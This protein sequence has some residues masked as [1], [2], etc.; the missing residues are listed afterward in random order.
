MFVLPSSYPELR[1]KHNWSEQD[2]SFPPT[3]TCVCFRWEMKWVFLQF[4]QHSIK[5]EDAKV[6]TNL[7]ENHHFENYF[8]TRFPPFAPPSCS[9]TP[10]KRGQQF[11]GIA[12]NESLR[13]SFCPSVFWPRFCVLANLISFFI[14]SCFCPVVDLFLP[15]FTFVYF[16]LSLST[17]LFKILA[18]RASRLVFFLFL[19]VEIISNFSP[20][21]ANLSNHSRKLLFLFRPLFNRSLLFLETLS[22][23]EIFLQV[24]HSILSSLSSLSFR[25]LW[26]L[27]LLVCAFVFALFHLCILLLVLSLFERPFLPFVCSFVCLC[28]GSMSISSFLYL[29]SFFLVFETFTFQLVSFLTL[30]KKKNLSFKCVWARVCGVGVLVSAG[31]WVGVRACKCKGKI[32][33]V[34]EWERG[35]ERKRER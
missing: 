12:P 22:C 24:F 5:L 2:F 17:V 28:V 10:A 11:F 4:L 14:R 8:S 31:V 30:E 20:S 26:S 6:N 16:C 33:I 15:L 29:F 32:E 35:G 25:S 13:Q 1:L 34:S 19:I 23:L 9:T 3:L 27:T 18:L 7:T 21:H